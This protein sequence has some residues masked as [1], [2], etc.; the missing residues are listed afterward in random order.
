MRCGE[1]RC[2][3]SEPAGDSSIALG[4][5][6]SREDADAAPV[7]VKTPREGGPCIGLEGWLRE[8]ACR[9]WSCCCWC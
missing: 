6:S 4:G 8:A 5:T 3:G 7:G 2:D 1:E 9:S